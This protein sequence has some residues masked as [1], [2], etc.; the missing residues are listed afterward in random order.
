M[1][2]KQI[3]AYLIKKVKEKEGLCLKWTSSITGVCDRLIFWNSKVFLIELKT[4]KGVVSERQK[5]VFKQLAD[6]GHLVYV[7]RSYEDVEAFITE[8][9]Y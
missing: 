2:E 4:K 5:L 7:L 6:Q 1:L 9:M 8:F 3:E